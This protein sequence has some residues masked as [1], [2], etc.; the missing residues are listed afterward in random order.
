MLVMESTEIEE[1]RMIGN[2]IQ[3]V[4]FVADYWNPVFSCA[5]EEEDVM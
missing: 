1:M 2:N 4:N 3:K 5:H